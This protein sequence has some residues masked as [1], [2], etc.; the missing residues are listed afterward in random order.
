M[1]MRHVLI[2]AICL[3]AAGVAAALAETGQ[4]PTAPPPD[5]SAPQN[6]VIR[7]LPN[8]SADS[9]VKPPNVDPGMSIPPPGTA[10]SGSKVV[11]K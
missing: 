7:P 10:G 8:S 1:L 5:A 4:P 2:G 9:T 11:P 6:G 3:A